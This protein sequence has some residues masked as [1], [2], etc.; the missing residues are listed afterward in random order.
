[1][2]ENSIKVKALNAIN[3][4]TNIVGGKN[5]TRSSK[6]Q[7]RRVEEGKIF[8]NSALSILMKSW[9]TITE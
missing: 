3:I 6:K 5:I 2:K 7:A 4:K 1:M 9:E 8:K